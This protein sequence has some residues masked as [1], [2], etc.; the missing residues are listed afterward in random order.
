MLTWG[1]GACRT[2]S[3]SDVDIL[4]YPDP[5]PQPATGDDPLLG[6]HKSTTVVVHISLAIPASVTPPDSIAALTVDLKSDE[7]LGV[8]DCAPIIRSSQCSSL[9]T[10][11]LHSFPRASTSAT[12][13]TRSR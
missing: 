13:R 2:V 11:H 12:I 9:P 6:E 7:T 3:L 8:S 4:L 10:L 1:E 5:S